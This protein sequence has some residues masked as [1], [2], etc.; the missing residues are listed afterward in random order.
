[1]KQYEQVLSAGIAVESTV[2]VMVS[3]ATGYM[4]SLQ[5]SNPEKCAAALVK[6]YLVKT[7]KELKDK[8]TQNTDRN[9]KIAEWV[10][11]GVEVWTVKNTFVETMFIFK[12]K[13]LNILPR[14]SAASGISKN[15]KSPGNLQEF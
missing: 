7:C 8:Y 11:V 3:V 2:R 6:K 5:Y 9:R 13:K 1:M 14:V 4:N 12:C 15:S 10:M